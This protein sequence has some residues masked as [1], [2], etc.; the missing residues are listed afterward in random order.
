MLE[1]FD[2]TSRESCTIRRIPTNTPLQALVTLND[3]VFHE[4]AVALGRRIV[5]E[6]GL[7][8]VER[9][10]YALRMIRLRPPDP[11]RVEIVQQLAEVEEQRFGED[12]EQALSFAAPKDSPLGGLPEG[13]DPAEYATWTLVAGVLLNLDEV[14]VK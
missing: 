14:L 6:G 11:E 5:Q 8:S 3:P 12:L 7:G 1:I 10:A 9:A 13:A 2:A 4:V